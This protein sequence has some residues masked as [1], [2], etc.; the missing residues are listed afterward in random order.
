[1]SEKI[2]ETIRFLRELRGEDETLNLVGIDDRGKLKPDTF[3]ADEWDAIAGFVIDQNR[4]NRRNLYFTMNRVDGEPE[5][6]K[7]SKADI[8]AGL[9]YGVDL[10]PPDDCGDLEAWRD[11]MVSELQQS[12]QPPTAIWCSGSGLQAAWKLRAPVPIESV[13]DREHHEAINAALARRFGGDATH[14]IDRLF[15]L[16]GTKNY[17][18]AT[19]RAKGRVVTQAYVIEAPNDHRFSPENFA[20]LVSEG[21]LPACGQIPPDIHTAAAVHDPEALIA[22]LPEALKDLVRSSPEKGDRS[23]Q[24]C[25]AICSLFEHG[26]WPDQVELLLR[27]HPHGVAE[28]FLTRGDLRQEVRRLYD[29][30]CRSAG[31]GKPKITDFVAF[32]PARK[33]IFE[34]TRDL[35]PAP[36]VDSQISPVNIGTQDEP[37]KIKA[38]RW[39]EQNRHV[40]QMTWAPG[41]DK[42]IPDQV[43]QDG[44]FIDHPGLRI[45][46]LYRPPSIELGDPAQAG[47]WID[48]IQS[49]YPDDSAHIINWL[50]HR[51]QRPGEKINHA[52]VLHGKQGIGKD[53][54]LRPAEVAVGPWNVQTIKPEDLLGQFTPF[55]KSVILL[56]NEGKDLGETSRYAFYERIKFFTT[57]PPNTIT[58]NEK[59]V[60]EYMVTNVASVIITTNHREDGMYL[61]PDDR[62]HYVASSDRDRSEFSDT[63]WREL[64]EWYE[65]GGTGHV[66]AYLNAHDL[67][68]FNPKAPPQQTDAFFSI[69]YA[70]RAPQDAPLCDALEKLGWPDALTLDH[71]RDAANSLQMHEFLEWLDGNRNGRIV[72]HRLSDAGYQQV[73]NPNNKQGYWRYRGARRVVYAKSALTGPERV[74]AAQRLEEEARTPASAD[75]TRLNDRRRQG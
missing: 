25:A 71:I 66:A 74:E 19:K 4:D 39:I 24:V 52:L 61:D 11:E 46:N 10:D 63:Y 14:N 41:A 27:A 75:V 18:N 43:I 55:V 31:P 70:N 62:R 47:P 49:V 3:A 56:I 59:H 2:Y 21:A 13:Q 36:S 48:H 1:M 7:P 29:K 50:A 44:E 73:P 37:K 8:S 17:P 60:P 69:V 54:L 12:Q 33:F 51:V 15:R 22:Q 28:K 6:G 68:G 20:D 9:C 72:G 30:W 5:H 58:C 67:T 40:E 42:I 64:H 35:W 34:P 65:N 23:E 57:T 16:P 45:F 38:S 26:L 32:L 53:T